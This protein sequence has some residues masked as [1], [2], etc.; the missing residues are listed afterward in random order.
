MPTLPAAFLDRP[1]AHRALH[2]AASGRPENSVEAIGAAVAA[3]Y[4]IEI[5]LQLSSDGE[6]MVF[7]D[8]DL[9][10]LTAQS[11]PVRQR[12]AA[13]LGTI[14]L[15]HGQAGIPTL[16]EV[17]ALV[18]GKAPLLIEFKDQDGAMGP[19][20]GA[21]ERAA[22]AALSGYDGPVA[23]MSFNPHSVAALARLAPDLPRGLTTCAFTAEDYPTLPPATRE[24]LRGIPDF[25]RTGASFISHHWRD[26]DNPR[27]TALRAAGTPVLCWTIR[28]PAEE[29]QA[30]KVAQNITFEGYAA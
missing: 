20:V 7:H 3:G 6:A 25:E 24:R 10:R 21:L 14:A 8:Y 4:G 17:L 16:A 18:A 2:D 26:L 27:V 5:D 9:A 23:L 29:A 28:T 11:G 13:E 12:S 15:R 30:R 19:D 22:V 1:I